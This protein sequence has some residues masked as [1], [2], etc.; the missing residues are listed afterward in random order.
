MCQRTSVYTKSNNSLCRLEKHYFSSNARQFTPTAPTP[1]LVCQRSSTQH[2]AVQ[3]PRRIVH[4]RWTYSRSCLSVR[5]RSCGKSEQEY[6]IKI[7]SPNFASTK[8][9]PR[10]ATISILPPPALSTVLWT[11]MVVVG[12]RTARRRKAE[13][14]QWVIHTQMTKTYTAPTWLENH[15]GLEVRH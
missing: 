7:V 3:K 14:G 9:P 8:P 5:S 11:R 15:D 6:E 2:A 12:G 1:Y 13:K 10:T 4:Y